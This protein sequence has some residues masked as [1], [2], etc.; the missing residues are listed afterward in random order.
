MSKTQGIINT[1]KAVVVNFYH[2][3]DQHQLT[4]TSSANIYIPFLV[5]EIHVKGIHTNFDADF[6]EI[7]FTS[8]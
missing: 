3:L 2:H 6:R 4:V 8:T 5:S 1:N 7:Y